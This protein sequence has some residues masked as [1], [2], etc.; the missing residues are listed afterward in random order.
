L[1]ALD[2]SIGDLHAMI[3]DK[4]IEI[5]QRLASRVLQYTQSFVEVAHVLSELDWYTYTMHFMF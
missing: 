3:A 4:E 1:I 2:E 5:I